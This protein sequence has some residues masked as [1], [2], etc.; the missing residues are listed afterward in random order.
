[1]TPV[2]NKLTSDP[3]DRPYVVPRVVV[4]LAVVEIVV[5]EIVIEPPVEEAR[6]PRHPQ[7]GVRSGGSSHRVAAA[8]HQAD[9]PALQREHILSPGNRP[10]TCEEGLVERGLVEPGLVE[11]GLVERGLVVPGLVVPGLVVPGLVDRASSTA[12]HRPAGT[13]TGAVHPVAVPSWGMPSSGG[14]TGP[15]RRRSRSNSSQPAPSTPSPATPASMTTPQSG[16]P[17]ARPVAEAT[18]SSTRTHLFSASECLGWSH[19]AARKVATRFDPEPWGYHRLV[20][21]RCVA[22]LGAGVGSRDAR[23]G[24]TVSDAQDV[25]P[26]ASPER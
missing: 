4:A 11:P 3:R 12:R 15:R 16:A 17:A 8:S 18:S 7:R 22:V 26:V 20:P 9:D 25:A 24:T 2:H 21:S 14:E 19:R 5:V 1:M 6:L 13:A 23:G 10:L